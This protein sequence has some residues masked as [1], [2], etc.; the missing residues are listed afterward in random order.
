MTHRRR[1]L[2]LHVD[3]DPV[4]RVM[5]HELLDLATWHR[6]EVVEAESFN[7]ALVVLKNTREPFEVALLDL[8]L[9]DRNPGDVV[10]MLGRLFPELPLI[11]LSTHEDWDTA[12]DCYEQGVLRFI[13]KTTDLTSES[14]EREILG[15]LEMHRRARH[16]VE[17]ARSQR[18]E[19]CRALSPPGSAPAEAQVL[20]P[21]LEA[22]E[23][24]HDR[25]IRELAE[26]W[27]AAAAQ[28]RR[29][30]EE[31]GALVAMR[32]LRRGLLLAG[33]R[34]TLPPSMAA[35]RELR[36]M[37]RDTPTDIYRDP[38]SALVSLETYLQETARAG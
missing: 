20:E 29:I 6:F 22:V 18:I 36:R 13:L 35:I 23:A 4:E 30:Y 33:E 10:R 32:E 9:P 15:A 19:T 5:V 37:R 38:H 2:V 14:L 25:A 17:L 24:A 31:T 27:P 21:H 11:V 34:E 28:L 7:G 3:D 8:S 1:I 16:Q 12:A 26:T